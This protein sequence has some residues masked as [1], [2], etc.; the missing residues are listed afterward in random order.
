[1]SDNK[2]MEGFVN[3]YNFINFPKTKAKAYTDEDRHTGVIHYTI[4]TKTP[5]FIPN[6]S[7]AAAFTE[8]SAAMPDHKSYDFFSYTE[9]DETKKYENE[10]HVPVIPGSE[11]RG[12]VRNVYETLT[13]SCMGVLNAETYPVKRSSATFKP[14]LL[15]R[16]TMGK[17]ELLEAESLRIGKGEKINGVIQAPKGF[18]NDHN[19]TE[20]FMNPQKKGQMYETIEKYGRSAGHYK[21]SGYLLKWGMGA[22]KRH[23]HVF[24][25]QKEKNNKDKKVNGIVVSKDVVERKLFPVLESYLSQPGLNDD[26][27]M[28]Y[29]EYRE[30]LKM[31][32]QGKKDAYFPVTYSIL[33]KNGIFYLAPA[34]F[35]KEMSNHNIGDVA[36][37]IAPCETD[38]CPACDLFGY[39]GKNNEEAKG[40]SVRFSDLY[41]AEKKPDAKDYYFK[42]NFGKVTLD[43][44]GEP[45]LG[46]VDFYLKRPQNAK[47]WTYDYYLE[48]NKINNTFLTRE[49]RQKGKV[50]QEDITLYQG[51]LRGRKYYWHHRIID[52]LD[53]P[54]AS[55]LNKT[56]RPV[57]EGI[58]F[59]GELYY[60]GIS[61]KQLKQL[62]W[63]LDSCKRGND[64]HKHLGLKLGGAKPFGYGSVACQVTS[65]QERSIQL[66]HGVLDYKMNDYPIAGISYQNVGFS[67]S[68][69]NEFYRIADLYAIP[70]N[71]EIIYPST[72]TKEENRKITD[73]NEKDKGFNWFVN[74]HGSG[75]PTMRKKARIK[76]VLPE[77]VN[78]NNPNGER[79]EDILL[80]YANDGGFKTKKNGGKSYN[81]QEKNKNWNNN[82]STKKRNS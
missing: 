74:N 52:M 77:I 21:R 26:N 47:F 6:S 10:Y 7:S 60:D 27:K 54:T 1:M 17:M 40:S 66:N 39:I 68:I 80:P 55:R 23:Y 57:K 11:M 70:K 12:V 36:G 67:S 62:I 2:K 4:T 33:E 14:A 44:L 34:T 58:S 61:E 37:K 63:I 22:S 13:D 56:I 30:D 59:T 41:V 28:A 38:F 25:T 46:N 50:E 81:G 43:T 65:V 18:E 24:I 73:D 51:M 48:S 29:E 79:I 71:V 32:L 9:L 72:K 42:S 8:T 64:K 49:E 76:N 16:N 3:P 82:K 19:G 5:L 69:E 20:I 75:M 78:K 15:H 31:F 53:Q 35:S 45:K